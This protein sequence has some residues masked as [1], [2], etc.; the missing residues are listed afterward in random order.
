MVAKDKFLGLQA[1]AVPPS[2]GRAEY[3]ENSP[4]RINPLYGIGAEY[5]NSPEVRK[6]AR[7]IAVGAV[8]AGISCAL[9]AGL[10]VVYSL[11]ASDAAAARQA[12]AARNAQAAQA[13]SR[14]QPPVSRTALAA[15]Q[16]EKAASGLDQATANVYKYQVT[17]AETGRTWAV[18]SALSPGLAHF[19]ATTATFDAGNFGLT[20]ATV[21][22]LITRF[23]RASIGAVEA[24]SPATAK[25]QWKAMVTAYKNLI[26]RCQQLGAAP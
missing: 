22:S 13:A 6:K 3:R 26:K 16:L 15:G 19:S 4:Y 14:I 24:S 17:C 10:V 20:D 21:N 8:V 1:P 25:R 7:R 5:E 12:R 18:C 23:E 9:V 2:G 11:H